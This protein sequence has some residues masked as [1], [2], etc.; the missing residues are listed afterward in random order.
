VLYF[1]VAHVIMLL[2]WEKDLTNHYPWVAMART[3]SEKATQDV[4]EAALDVLLE[5]GVARFTVDAVVARSGVA[6]TTVY[7]WW[8]NRQALILDAIHAQLTASATPNT[9]DT[10]ADLA[11]YLAPFA[12]AAHDSPASRLMPDLCAA[13]RR[14]PDLAGL[15]D[16]LL[17]EKRQPVIT[18]LELAR[19]RGEIAADADLDQLATMIIGPLA[20]TKSLRGIPVDPALLTSAIDA[21]L[22]Y[23]A[24]ERVAT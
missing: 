15:R 18:I 1:H 11:A 13:A 4:I 10:R 23:G 9:G 6:K 20:Y 2:T 16:V 21:A 24:R 12:T 5:E 17:T 7:R 19:A 8:P 14:D 22:A 3:R